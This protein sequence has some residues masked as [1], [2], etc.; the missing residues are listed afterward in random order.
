MNNILLEL[1]AVWAHHKCLLVYYINY[2]FHIS[3][4]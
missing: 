4:L 3:G 2:H 1:V